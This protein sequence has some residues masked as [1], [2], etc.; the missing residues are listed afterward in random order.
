[1]T[2]LFNE[3]KR[4]HVIRVAGIY[5]IVG[6]VLLQ[7][8][9]MLEGA[10]GLPD[11]FDGM[12]VAALI[13][14]FPVAMLLAWAYELTPDGVK[15]TESATGETGSASSSRLDVAIVTGLAIVIGIGVWQQL[16]TPDTVQVVNP[17]GA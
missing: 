17:P 13:L 11:W 14:G 10:I 15:R 7:L 9:N 1:L 8:A 6:W 12:V 16:T 3:L 4:R 5:A 2:T